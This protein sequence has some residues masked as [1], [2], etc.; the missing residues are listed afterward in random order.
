MAHVITDNRH[1]INIAN[2]IRDNSFGN[3]EGPLPVT[4]FPQCIGEIS[5]IGQAEGKA[6]GYAQGLEEGKQ[7][8]I[9][10][11]YDRFWDAYHAPGDNYNAFR[12]SGHGW[13]NATFT[14]K[15]DIVPIGDSMQMFYACYIVNLTECLER[16]GVSLDFSQCTGRVD[17]MFAYST[18][19]EDIP[20]LD[21]RNAKRG[22]DN[23]DLLNGMFSGC[24][25]LRTIRGFHIGEDGTSGYNTAFQ[26]CTS[27]ENITFYGVIGRNGLNLQWSTKLTHDSLMSVINA[28]KDYS[29]DTSGIT[30]A[31]TLGTTNLAKLTDTEKAIATQRGWTL[32]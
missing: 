12:F 7:A 23:S 25:N 5:T 22:S 15:Q 19:I 4:E 9:Q 8:G 11:E 1:Y 21:F 28:L 27:L 20:M 10:S 13:T 16:Q 6:E 17:Q 29:E 14:P 2:A 24:R 32:A 26:N 30:W 18:C 3:I 31:I